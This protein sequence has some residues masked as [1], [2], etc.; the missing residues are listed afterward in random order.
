MSSLKGTSIGIASSVVA[1]IALIV[2]ATSLALT[3]E[4]RGGA[5][6]THMVLVASLVVA[7]GAAT[8]T[9]ISFWRSGSSQMAIGLSLFAFGLVAMIGAVLSKDST[10]A[11]LLPVLAMAL[12]VGAIIVV[13]RFFLVLKRQAPSS[14]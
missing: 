1:H 14:S 13:V 7:C 5:T 12:F 2:A 9:A 4:S 3:L 6:T 10:A 11:V 8:F